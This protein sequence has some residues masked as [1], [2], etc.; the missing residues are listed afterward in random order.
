MTL[1]VTDTSEECLI[2]NLKVIEKSL[3][4]S[5]FYLNLQ[6]GSVRQDTSEDIHNIYR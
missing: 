6:K 2:S 4:Y 5:K 3:L 1:T